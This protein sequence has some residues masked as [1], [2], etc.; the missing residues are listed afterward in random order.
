MD[1]TYAGVAILVREPQGTPLAG[2]AV[3]RLE[4]PATSFNLTGTTLG[5][6][7]FFDRIPVGNYIVE[8]SAPGYRVT[9]EEIEVLSAK[10]RVAFYI[11]LL[12]E[13][14]ASTPAA[15]LLV[16]PLLSPKARKA[17]DEALEALRSGDLA[18]A[19]KHL[20]AARKLAPSHPDVSYLLGMLAMRR[21]QLA[22]AQTHLEKALQM[23]P[24][25]GDALA[26]LGEVFLRRGDEAQAVRNLEQALV[27]SPDTWQARGL[28]AAIYLRRGDLEKALPH[29]ERAVELTK[30]KVPGFRLLLAQ[31]HAGR[32]NVNEAEQQ[33]KLLL[34]ENPNSADAKEARR[35]LAELR[36]RPAG[37]PAPA[38][39]KPAAAAP[40]AAN[41]TLPLPRTGNNWAPRAVDE[42]SA[43][44][45]ADVPCS[46]PDVLAGTARQVQALVNSL[47]RITATERILYEEL[48]GDG[49][50]TFWEDRDLNYVVSFVQPRQDILSVEEY[51]RPLKKEESSPRMTSTGLVALVLLFHPLYVSDFEAACA[52]LGQWRGRPV[53]IVDFQQSPDR[54]ARVRTYRTTAG[55]FNVRLKGRAWIDANSYNVVRLETDLLEPLREARLERDHMV[56]EY[57]PVQFKK[58]DSSLWLPVR[59]ELY[60]LFRDRWYRVRHTLR[61]YMLFSIETRDKIAAPPQPPPQP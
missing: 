30:G 6:E 56:I 11:T 13:T 27:H 50:T 17:L 2:L 44:V 4:S 1:P 36:P 55:V 47:E 61:D 37:S 23:F 54:P 18:K 20:D 3:V 19:E 32:K 46:L 8:V 5:G 53:W 51:R 33:L 12:P 9:R 14:P 7:A 41:A 29:A 58:T 45:A 52:G 16:P 21:N 57:G 34:E 28:L 38:R 22:E 15:T 26:A 39:A 40:L 42:L 49:A 10:P 48:N 25:H 35:M 43:E 31:V 60:S 24:G 59:A